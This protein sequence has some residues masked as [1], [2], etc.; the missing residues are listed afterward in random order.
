[1]ILSEGESVFMILPDDEVSVSVVNR[2]TSRS[3]ENMPS[4]ESGGIVYRLVEVISPVHTSEAIYQWY[5]KGE[6]DAA[7]EALQ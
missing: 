3:K 4:K 5:L 6:I 7:W 2:S 1:M